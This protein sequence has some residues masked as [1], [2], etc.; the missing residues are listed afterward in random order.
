MDQV[1]H[2]LAASGPLAIVL[3]VAVWAL[4]Q[5]TERQEKQFRDLQRE[6]EATTRELNA[7]R[8]GDR[9]ACEAKLTKLYGELLT[10]VQTLSAAVSRGG[11]QRG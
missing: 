8:L 1:W 11:D 5:K 6:S 4:W 3:A 7:L 9:D 2:S 10:T